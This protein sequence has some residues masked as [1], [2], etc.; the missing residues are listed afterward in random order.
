MAVSKGEK[1]HP[2]SHLPLTEIMAEVIIDHDY[3]V[4]EHV[5]TQELNTWYEDTR[6]AQAVMCI[7]NSRSKWEVELFKIPI[8]I[9]LHRLVLWICARHFHTSPLFFMQGGDGGYP[10]LPVFFLIFFFTLPTVYTSFFFR[11]P[12]ALDSSGR[13][14]LL[15]QQFHR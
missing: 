15:S 1:C 2:F 7:W 3:C 11:K 14:Y 4:S 5:S 12:R 10:L 9:Q 8:N 6:R 13:K